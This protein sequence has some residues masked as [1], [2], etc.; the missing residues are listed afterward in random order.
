MKKLT[1]TALRQKIF[2]VADEVLATGVPAVIERNG[3][4]LLLSPKAAATGSR[5]LKLKLK[6]RKLIVGDAASLH[7][8]QVGT[9]REPGNLA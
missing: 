6:R 2:Q 3:Q 9:W 8:Q 4:V 1:L 5:Q 7:E